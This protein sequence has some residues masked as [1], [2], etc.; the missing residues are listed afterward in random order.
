MDDHRDPRDPGQPREDV[1]SWLQA[2]IDPLPPPPGTF[3]LIRRRVRRR[4]YRQVALSA[5]VAAAVA[6]AVIVV[7]RVATSVLHVNQNNA[8][9]AASAGSPR[10]TTH[11]SRGQVGSGAASGRASPV[12]S[13]TPTAPAPVP[14]P[15]NFQAT[16]AT[17]VGPHTGWV[18][19]QAGV[20]GH[21]ATQYCTSVARTGDAG[22]TWTGVPAP[23]TGA[24]NGD[25]GVGQVRFLNEND[26]WAF[27]PQLFATTDGGQHW[28]Q[29]GPQ[30]LRVTA[31]ETVGTRAFA[32]FASCTGTGPEFAAQCTK[33]SLYSTGAGQDG[34]T[35]V[36]GAADLSN[37]GQ[38][39]SAS[40]V[41]T[42]GGGYLLAP[43]GSVYAGPVDGGGPWKQVSSRPAGT[44]SCA[45]G[46]AQADGQPSGA[47]LSAAS[48]AAMV[49]ACTSPGGGAQVFTSTD[50]GGRWQQA[51]TVSGGNRVTTAAIQPGGEIV[52][53]TSD[54]IQVSRDG[55]QT[56]QVEA[57]GTAGPRGGFGWVGMTS[58]GQGIALPADPFQHTL[59]FTFDGGH[60]WKASPISGP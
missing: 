6:G 54:G 42:S 46:A 15:Q 14:V 33:F 52:L 53:S 51:G 5:A 13:V 39:G 18:I 2:R 24:P 50:G 1:D 10:P 40:L 3:D 12:P 55:G 57:A 45:P 31:L 20:P 37:G 44:V 17:F 7:P 30:G 47:L 22:Q 48:S 41:L 16:S 59:W 43:D 27:G 23:A 35:R 21:C 4:R 34:W 32:I 25:S 56:W 28:A 49:L 8:N 36:G 11:I 19:G 38:D 26:G 9:S 58:P 29:Q 60:I